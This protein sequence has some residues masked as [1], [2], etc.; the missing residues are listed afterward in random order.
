MNHNALVHN[1]GDD[2]AVVI[3]DMATGETA[4]AVT[5]EGSSEGTVTTV[6]DIPLGHKVAL[7]DIAEGAEVIK[8]GR[9]IGKATQAI[10]A[11]A[12]VHTHNV[13]TIRWA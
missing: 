5:L 6:N 3:K 2:V 12:H 10:K 4:A 1:S 11:G 9:A 13:K 7:R 8:Y